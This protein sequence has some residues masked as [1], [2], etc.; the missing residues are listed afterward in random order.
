MCDTN[1]ISAAFLEEKE[2]DIAMTFL[3]NHRQKHLIVI[4]KEILGEIIGVL[5][6]KSGNDQLALDNITK[7]LSHLKD[8]IVES[9]PYSEEEFRE[10]LNKIWDSKELRCGYA[11]RIHIANAI[12]SKIKFCTLEEKIREDAKTVNDI[13]SEEGYKFE[14]YNLH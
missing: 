5:L 9:P 2:Q 13:V 6:T 4:T 11:D 3:E 12:F 8:F 14:L 7:F 1:V 10:V